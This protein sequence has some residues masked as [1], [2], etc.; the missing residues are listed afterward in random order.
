MEEIR[1]VIQ[2]CQNDTDC[3]RVQ[4]LSR[5]NEPFTT[6]ACAGTCDN[7]ESTE[8]VIDQ[9][10]SIPAKNLLRL[11]E[12]AQEINEKV[13]R[14]ACIAAFRGSQQR[15]IINKGYHQLGLYGIGKDIEQGQAERL[16]DQL[17]FLEAIES[18]VVMGPQYP[19]TY[20]RVCLILLF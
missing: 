8:G 14:T 12:Q 15:D 2:F 10:M 13:S 5:F 9:D 6:D 17:T 20:N 16:F 18:F 3:R 19:V 7:C 1:A 4:L 11:V